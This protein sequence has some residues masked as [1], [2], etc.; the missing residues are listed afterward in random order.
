[1]TVIKLVMKRVMAVLI[2]LSVLAVGWMF[3]FANTPLRL[4]QSPYEFALKQGSSLRAIAK[5]FRAE[6]LLSEPWSFIAL[7]KVFGKE[8]DIKA[9][10][11]QLDKEITPFQ[12]VL[13]ITRG[14]VSQSG[15]IF[16]EGWNFRQIRKV[17]NEHPAIRHDSI[18]LSDKDLLNRLG[19]REDNAEGLF[20]PDTY[21][22][23][24]GMSDLSLLKRAHQI[25]AH[26]LDEAWRGRSPGLPYFTPYEALIMASIVEKE[27][28]RAS[29]RPMIAGVFINRLRIGMRLQ[30]DPTVIYG[31]GETFDGNLH[32]RDLI[33]DNAY[34]TYTRAGLPPTPIAMPGWASIQAALH[35]SATSALYFVS[36]GDGSH[37]FSRSLQEHNQAVT[38]Y[39]KTPTRN[40]INNTA[41]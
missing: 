41:Q 31:L 1:M 17:L 13:K 14:D 39:Q 37:Q 12:L 10:N 16:I 20:F 30:T 7:A 19:I 18:D 2:L 15:I 40:K 3:Y 28:G 5:Q 22:F 38:R 36:K 35:P 6:G 23:S 29:E 33:A 25:M 21:Y 24:N 9:G 11:Y 4:P 27:T 26:R 8:G 34:N 32:K